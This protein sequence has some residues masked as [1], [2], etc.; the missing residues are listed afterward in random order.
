MLVDEKGVELHV[1][2]G[3]GLGRVLFDHPHH[4]NTSVLAKDSDVKIIQVLGSSCA[5]EL[6]CHDACVHQPPC[7]P[8]CAY[9]PLSSFRA[10]GEA[11]GLLLLKTAWPSVLRTVYGDHDRFQSNYF[12]PFPGYY[13]TGTPSGFL[14]TSAFPGCKSKK[15]D[16]QKWLDRY[17]KAATAL[18]QH[19]QETGEFVIMPSNPPFHAAPMR[20]VW[21]V[22]A[23]L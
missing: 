6:S 3:R 17:Q 4:K 22:C 16:G 14:C 15:R 19:E 18:L 1:R 20:R 8:A 11:E 9:E 13:F 23:T 10:Q 5:H 2:G 21:L 12:S 7:H